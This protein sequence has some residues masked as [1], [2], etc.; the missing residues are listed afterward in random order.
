MK[1][2]YSLA[3]FS[4]AFSIITLAQ[5][6]RPVQA[7]QPKN[8]LISNSNAIASSPETNFVPVKELSPADLELL[9]APQNDNCSSGLN[10]TNTLVPDAS[11]TAGTV[12]QATMEGGESIGCLTN[13]T[14]SVWYSFVATQS[15]MFVTVQ[16]SGV[17]VCSINFGFVVWKYNGS[18]PPN[19]SYVGCK[20]YTSYGSGVGQEIFSNLNLTG[21]TIGATYVIEINYYTSCPNNTKSFCVRVGTPTTCTTCSNPCGPLCVYNSASSPS[22]SWVTSN[23]PSYNLRPPMNNSDNRT[24]CFTFTATNTTMNLQMI[25]QG[26]GCP[27]GGNVYSAS[28]TLQASTCAGIIASGTLSAGFP[29]LTGLTVGQNYVLC[30]T[31][32]AA[33]SQDVNWPYLY[34]ASALPI[35]LISFQARAN[36]SDI[37]VTWTT[38]SEINT[39]EFVIERTIDGQHF[40]EIKRLKAA[41]NSTSILNYKVTDD[42]PFVG[43]NYYRLKE[44][45]YDGTITSGALVVARF[46]R[47][48]NT[49]S[50]VPNPAQTQIGISFISSKNTTIGITVID[51]KGMTVLSKNVSTTNDG[52]N[53]IPLNI[54]SLQPGIYSI[55][56]SGDNENLNTRF[57]KE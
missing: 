23:C 4:L 17:L 18:C 40:T 20:N 19:T 28:Y 37:N 38:A 15:N 5:D 45:D 11:C 3:T 35:E 6:A 50:I 30:Y 13:G 36:R 8:V 16:N 48:V 44:I 49:L 57:V 7:L 25:L 51:A 55:L 22:V 21:L 12:S 24:M 10:A 39:S 54:A 53:S 41:G 47:D 42:K 1:K 56:L 43:N 46:A 52:F 31:W 26:Y 9:A 27:V 33:C 32:Q 14:T 29:P 2:F 34:A